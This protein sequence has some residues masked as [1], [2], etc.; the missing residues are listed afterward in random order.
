MKKLTI[1]F[2]S[3]LV[4]CVAVVLMSTLVTERLNAYKTEKE[5][6]AVEMGF[7]ERLATVDEYIPFL[8]AG[9]D[10]VETWQKRENYARAVYNAALLYGAIL[11]AFVGAYAALNMF[12]YQRKPYKYQV[13]GLV[14]VFA[15]LS[16]LFL[17]LKSPFIEIMAYKK[18]LAFEVPLLG[19]YTFDGR[20]YFLYQNKSVFQLI[21]ILYTGGNFLVAIAVAMFSVIFPLF[22]AIMSIIVLLSPQ[23]PVSMNRYK[24]I[25][26][27]G[28]WSMADVFV[29]AIFLAF[30][31]YSNMEVGID[32]GSS[33]LIG[34]YF[35]MLFVVL[36]IN[37][38][39]YLKKAM[40]H[41][42]EIPNGI[43]EVDFEVKEGE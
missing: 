20:I 15:S 5:Q 23:K 37:S 6:I 21:G 8:G 9:E 31:A 35:Y 19:D 40:K 29:A 41:A 7:E 25:R 24:M 33:T 43:L 1:L 11:L 28:K 12:I 14:M 36:A 13:Y 32:T 22:K 2:I 27:L 16:F 18:D 34:T 3:T 4:L 42:Q 10:K 30:F 26:N 38:G 17:G 39:H